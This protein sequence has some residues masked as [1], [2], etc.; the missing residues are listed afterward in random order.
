MAQISHYIGY[1]AKRATLE[2]TASNKED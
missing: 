2:T 1:R